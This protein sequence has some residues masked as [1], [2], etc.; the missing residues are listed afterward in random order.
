[1]YRG[2]LTI[3]VYLLILLYELCI[4]ARTWI[5]VRMSKKFVTGEIGYLV[6]SFS[7]ENCHCI[8]VVNKR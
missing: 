1:M 5:K 6:P 8:V 3:S 4:N 7:L 2:I